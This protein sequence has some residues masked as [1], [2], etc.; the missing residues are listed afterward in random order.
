MFNLQDNY[1]RSLFSLLLI[2]FAFGSPVLFLSNNKAIAQSTTQ[3]KL[4]NQNIFE[5]WINSIWRRRPKRPLGARSG[6]CLIAPGLVETYTIWHNRPLF[7]WHT[8][9]KNQEVQ[10]VLRERHSKE[11]LW[12]QKVNIADQKVLYTGKKPLEP[13]KFYQWKLEEINSPTSW[14]TFQIMPAGDRAAIQKGLQALELDSKSKL[15]SEEIA[16]KKAEY[17]LDYKIKSQGNTHPWADALQAMYQVEKPSPSFVKKREE[18][19]SNICTSP[20]NTTTSKP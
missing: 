14:T 2:S 11:S 7:L 20:S 13:G 16:L 5:R 19:V 4:V 3:P 17:F 18:L 15:T 1:R 6:I 8:A 9:K 12:K 10:L